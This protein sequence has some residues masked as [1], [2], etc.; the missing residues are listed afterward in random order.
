MLRKSYLGLAVKVHPDKFPGLS[1]TEEEE[2]NENFQNMANAYEQ[3]ILE[4]THPGAG[5][6]SCAAAPGTAAPVSPDRRPPRKRSCRRPR[7][8]TVEEMEAE[9]QAGFDFQQA[10]KDGFWSKVAIDKKKKGR[11]P[12]LVRLNRSKTGSKAQTALG[13]GR[14]RA[15]K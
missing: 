1:V 7:W 11:E 15:A 13:T 6:G 2:A 12:G 5:G 4:I 8:A 3:R 9:Y 10:E 14:A